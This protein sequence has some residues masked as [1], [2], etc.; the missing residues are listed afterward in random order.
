MIVTQQERPESDL[1]LYFQHVFCIKPFE[2]SPQCITY[3]P[4]NSG[5]LEDLVLFGDDQGY[6]NVLKL[7]AKD[8]T[9]KNA[10]DS[11]KRQTQ[12]PTNINITP[13]KLSQ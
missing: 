4:N 11:D 9:P 2:N 8:L 13:D 1:H 6:I 5:T 7:V 3:V 10:K 12:I